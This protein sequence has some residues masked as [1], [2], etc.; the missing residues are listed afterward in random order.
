[1][2]NHIL[3]TVSLVAEPA[4]IDA[5]AELLTKQEEGETVVTFE[6][7]LPIPEEEDWYDWCVK[8]WGTKWDAY[9]TERVARRTWRDGRD[10]LILTFQTAWAPPTEFFAAL[11]AAYDV[12]VAGLWKDEMSEGLEGYGTWEKYLNV[13]SI[14]QRLREHTS[15]YKQ[16]GVYLREDGSYVVVMG[17]GG[18]PLGW[19]AQAQRLLAEKE[20]FAA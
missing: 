10:Q 18:L 19:Q 8:H 2:P 20:G 16:P 11:T 14:R 12:E 5:L 15:E 1:M 9:S 17:D 7:F 6:Q 13:A 4:V 3:N